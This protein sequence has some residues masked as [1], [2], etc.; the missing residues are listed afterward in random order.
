M[1]RTALFLQRLD[2]MFPAPVS[3]VSS[4]MYNSNDTTTGWKAI[5]TNPIQHIR[6]SRRDR[7]KNKTR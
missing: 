2:E 1:T 4:S 5:N 6:E 3:T 7:R